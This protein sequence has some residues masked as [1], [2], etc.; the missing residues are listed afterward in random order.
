MTQYRNIYNFF[1]L[2][3][4]F[5]CKY[6]GHCIRCHAHFG[7][8]RLSRHFR[9]HLDVIHRFDMGF[10]IC[11]GE[12]HTAGSAVSRPVKHCIPA[13]TQCRNVCDFFALGVGFSFKRHSCCARCH[14]HFDT[15]RL[16]RHFRC[17][18]DVIHR[19][20]MCFIMSTGECRAAGPAVSR[21]VKCRIPAVTQCRNFLIRRIVAVC[22]RIIKIPFT[23]LLYHTHFQKQ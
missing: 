21:P 2:G 17:H 22:A 19:F 13:V 15:R 23:S 1:G 18:L 3:V 8:C 4:G 9:C 16:S 5:S 7:T 12:C 10:I 6:H 11:T 20:N 14:A